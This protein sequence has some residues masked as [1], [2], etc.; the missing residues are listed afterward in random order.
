MARV[1]WQMVCLSRSMSKITEAGWA[2][3][4]RSPFLD[5]DTTASAKGM[6]TTHSSSPV[7]CAHYDRAPGSLARAY[8]K[9][10]N[11]LRTMSRLQSRL[12]KLEAVMTGGRGLIPHSPRRRCRLPRGAKESSSGTLFE[13]W[14]CLS[15]EG[16]QFASHVLQ[17]NTSAPD[18]SSASNSFLLNVTVCSWSFGHTISKSMR[19]LIS[20][21]LVRAIRGCARS[22]SFL[23][24]DGSASSDLPDLWRCPTAMRGFAASRKLPFYDDGRRCLPRSFVDAESWVDQPSRDRRACAGSSRR[25]TLRATRRSR[26]RR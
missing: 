22:I 25:P 20:L 16:G 24:P 4:F 14:R 7:R 6:E 2:G 3:T 21:P 8:R 26:S 5:K 17:W 13:F 18:F 15:W 9:C 11:H 12:R 23:T 1:K 10:S 19:S